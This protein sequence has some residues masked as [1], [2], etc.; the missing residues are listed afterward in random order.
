MAIEISASD[1]N[2]EFAVV[3]ITADALTLQKA[4]GTIANIPLPEGSK[5]IFSEEVHVME[6]AQLMQK[7]HDEMASD[8]MEAAL[9]G[10]I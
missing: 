8:Y 3:T 4:D 10:K 5:V 9:K 6:L 1:N 2:P 7:L